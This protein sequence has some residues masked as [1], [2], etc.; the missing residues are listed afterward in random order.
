MA[1]KRKTTTESA[2]KERVRKA[3]AEL[4]AAIRDLA[5]DGSFAVWEEGL[6]ELTNEVRKE[7]T[8]GKLQALADE[9]GDEVEVKGKTYKR[10]QSGAVKYYGLSGCM[11]VTRSTYREVGV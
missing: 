8:Q 3:Q 4:A 9:V 7:A 11:L 5:P 1:T 6:L 10:H 2:K